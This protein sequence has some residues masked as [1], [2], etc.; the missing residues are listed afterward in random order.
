MAAL[1]FSISISGVAFILT[2]E[3]K[4]DDLA[5]IQVMPLSSFPPPPRLITL[6]TMN[7]FQ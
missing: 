5:V 3:G 6:I 1:I 2:E 4:E 7:A